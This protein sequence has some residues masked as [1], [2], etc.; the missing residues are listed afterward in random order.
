MGLAELSRENGLPKAT[1]LRLV[2]S[3]VS[4]GPVARDET[5]AAHLQDR[6]FWIRLVPFL[7]PAQSLV[8][9]VA[10]ILQDLAIQEGA[11]ALLL[12]P[13]AKGRIGTFPLDAFPPKHVF[14]DP[15]AAPNVPLHMLAGG[16]CC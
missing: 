12:L 8:S 1:V 9:D 16:K 14:V 10:A 3:L 2:R 7:R 15:A 5:S 11:S 4:A 6:A 13:E